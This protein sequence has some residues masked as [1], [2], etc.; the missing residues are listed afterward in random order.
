MKIQSSMAIAAACCGAALLAGCSSGEAAESAVDAETSAAPE[1]LGSVDDT[2]WQ[3][4]TGLTGEVS[5]VSDGVAQ[6]QDGSTQTAVSFTDDTAISQE[7]ELALADITAGACVLATLGDDDTATS[8]AVTEA[9]EDGECASGFGGRGLGGGMGGEMPEGGQLPDDMPTAMP[10]DG[11]TPELDL[12]DDM[13]TAMPEDGG[14]DMAQR[15]NGTVIEVTAVGLTVE[16]TDGE[17][18]AVL[19]GDDTAITGTEEAGTDAIAVGMCMT[20]TGEA[21]DAGGYDAAEISLFAAGDDGCVT[22]TGFGGQGGMPGG[23]E[24][25]PMGEGDE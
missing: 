10:E 21:D 17:T 13:S 22:M 9:D 7:V 15:V 3:G 25:G 11:E 5:Y 24:G 18:T 14:F 2:G 16:D 23:R 8:I 19:V 6:V 12:P 20:A 1:I 4:P